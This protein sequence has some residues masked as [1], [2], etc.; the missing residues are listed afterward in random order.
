MRLVT[1]AEGL[2]YDPIANDV[3]CSEF[4]EPWAK[5]R[6]RASGCVH[7]V[8]KNTVRGEGDSK[9]TLST[10]RRYSADSNRYVILDL[11]VWTLPP[12]SLGA[13]AV[14]FVAPAHNKA[15]TLEECDALKVL[16]MFRPAINSML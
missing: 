7:C 4:S 9:S 16:P 1:P 2:E 13:V 5:Y 6:M 14:L 12:K 15:K 10:P 3:P 8:R 11:P